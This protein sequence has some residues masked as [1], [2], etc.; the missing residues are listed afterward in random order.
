VNY[1]SIKG[2]GNALLDAIPSNA[3]S[4]GYKDFKDQV[5]KHF[6]NK[7]LHEPMK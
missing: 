5:D 4:I 6:R 1:D 3:T 2:I 7:P